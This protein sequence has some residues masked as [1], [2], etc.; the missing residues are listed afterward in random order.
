[1]AFMLGECEDSMV[2]DQELSSAWWHVG[3]FFYEFA[4]LESSVNEAF[5]VLFNMRYNATLYQLIASRLSFDERLELITLG[6]RRKGV[7]KVAG[8]IDNVVRPLLEVRNLSLIARSALT[9][10]WAKM[11]MSASQALV[12]ITSAGPATSSFQNE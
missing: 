11:L 8:L 10:A 3:R 6:L 2:S 9:S 7:N 1:M 4:I 5:E 12:S